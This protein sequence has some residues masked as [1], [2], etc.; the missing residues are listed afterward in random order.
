MAIIFTNLILE[1]ILDSVTSFGLYIFD[2]KNPI[3]ILLRVKEFDIPLNRIDIWVTE[4]IKAS[5]STKQELNYNQIS[6]SRSRVKKLIE[7][8][9][10]EID[11]IIINDPSFKIKVDQTIKIVLPT[12]EDPIPLP[13]NINLE[14][15]YEDEFLII[16]N[17]KAG[18]VVHPAPGSPD[19]T[20][21]NALLYHCGK[22]LQG[23]GGVKRPGI[24]HRLDKNTSGVMVVAKTELS[25]FKLCEM[26]NHH[27]L[28]RRYHAIVWGQPKN[29]GLV[30]K[31]IGR[32]FVNRKK[33]AISEK[34][35]MALTKWKILDIY[36]PLATLIECKLETGRTHQIRVHL[37]D[38]GHS[39]V[40]D[41]LYGKP[42]TQK[43]LENNLYKQKFQLVK[44]FDRQA[45]HAKKLSFNHP[46]TS[47]FLEFETP[48][49][50]D[51]VNLINILKN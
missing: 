48:I 12:P 7:N 37:S 22:R 44:S 21:V 41:P 2:M 15:I 25:H 3:K 14:V 30:E 10:L 13:Q 6:L 46:I 36:P 31:P 9:N 1:S 32:S 42:L 45:L 29:K 40:G 17:K 20:L 8:N 28:D 51:M 11:G 50:N 38:L 39:V 47:K 33:M 24:V 4:A 18:I 27:D 34:G 16:L 5:N 19:R 23:I 35:K 26:F 49:P 43:K